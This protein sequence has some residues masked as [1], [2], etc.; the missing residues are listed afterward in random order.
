MASRQIV[1]GNW[2]MHGSLAEVR[3]WAGQLP[4][5][6]LTEAVEWGVCPPAVYL[7]AMATAL[8]DAPVELGAQDVSAHA[9]GAHTGEIAADMLAELGCRYVL[10]GHSER[11]Q[12]DAGEDRRV[13]AKLEQALAAGLTPIL[14]VGET[15]AQRE[16]GAALAN[17]ARQQTTRNTQAA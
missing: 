1:V 6:A 14:C 3:D 16:T 10:V 7:P 4:G 13:P 2:K 11:R 8:A 15:Q 12:A 5:L 17:V 9:R